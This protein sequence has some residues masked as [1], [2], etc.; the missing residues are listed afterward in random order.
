MGYTCR[1]KSLG[2]L[3]LDTRFGSDITRLRHMSLHRS[4]EPWLGILML[5]T[6]FPRV[7]GDIG[8]P[9]TFDMPVRYAVVRGASPQRIV[10]EQD[11]GY[12][13]AFI[14]AAQAL[15]REG[16]SAITTSCG[17]LVRWQ[18]ELQASVGVP[19]WSSSLL[20][21]PE[22]TQAGVITIDA[23]SLD[24]EHL[25]C[26]GA[27]VHTPVEGIAADSALHRTL[28]DD[29]P[30][31][32]VND[33]QQQVVSAAQRLLARHPGLTDIVLECANMPPYAE[34]VRH[35]TG[36]RVHDITTLVAKRWATLEL[37]D[38]T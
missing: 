36:R 33:A 5:D 11:A 38:R 19:L 37:V 20:L 6:R 29:L 2:I 30:Q 7:L 13:A 17:F 21:L 10:R 9:S 27:A 31:L 28:L 34:A 23:A 25:R 12:L 35:S 26:A 22:L 16:A 18:R 24:A 32:D 15:E 1:A 3:M 4:A 8:H 14:E